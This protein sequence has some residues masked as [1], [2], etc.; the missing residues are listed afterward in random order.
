MKTCCIESCDSEC[1]KGRRYCHKHYLERIAILRK[2]KKDQGLKVRTLYENTCCSCKKVFQGSRKDQL[3]CS[4]DCFAAFNKTSKNPYIY[5]SKNY[6]DNLWEHRNIA[7][8]I[9]NVK[10]ETNEV[11]HHIDE[12][13]KNNDISNL[14]IIS[15]KDHASLHRFLDRQRAL[16]ERS[17]NGN[18]E[19]CWKTL[20]V[21][22]TTT[23]LE[24]TNVNVRK[25]TEI[26]QSAAEPL[27]NVEGSETMHVTSLVDEDIVQTTTSE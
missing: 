27:L 25:L 6:K 17:N 3:F 7:E 4:R 9:L 5:D 1:E 12:D 10:L 18:D 22:L 13:P 20:I 15:R 14:L 24:T 8:N 23:W 21:P 11:V 19:N 2:T 16:L 26:G